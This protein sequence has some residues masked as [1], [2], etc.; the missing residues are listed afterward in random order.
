M[1]KVQV[2]VAGGSVQQKDSGVT[3][4]ELAQSV[5]AEGFIATVNGEPVDNDYEVEDYEFV[6]FAKPVKAG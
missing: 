5:G 6:S 3:I 2:Q 1:A 4:G